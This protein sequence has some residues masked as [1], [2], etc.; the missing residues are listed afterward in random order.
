MELYNFYSEQVS[1]KD[2]KKTNDLKEL[3]NELK[4]TFK[5]EFIY[6]VDRNESICIMGQIYGEDT[7]L[8]DLDL[9][10]EFNIYDIKY[11]YFN[12]YLPCDNNIN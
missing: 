1:K 5:D 9:L 3:F 11:T 10:I 2:T 12:A 6:L 4:I 7:N 8:G